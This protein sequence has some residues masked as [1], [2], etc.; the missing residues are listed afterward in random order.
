M[1]RI[2]PV[3]RWLIEVL[4]SISRSYEEAIYQAAAS[5]TPLLTDHMF[6][7]LFAAGLLG[8]GTGLLGSAIFWLPRTRRVSDASV[9]STAMRASRWPRP[10]LLAAAVMLV[11]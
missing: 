8:V 2:V 6:V 5:G 9:A 7:A 11:T 4:S 10:V 3:G 1:K